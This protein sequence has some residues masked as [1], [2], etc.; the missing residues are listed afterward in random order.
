V[1]LGARPRGLP[2][3]DYVFLVSQVGPKGSPERSR[4]DE[5]HDGIVAPV[6]QQFD[7]SVHRA[8]RD[9]TPG[10][11]TTQ[12]IR[13]L[14]D[15]KI[16]VADLTGRNP[17][18]YYELG[19]AHAFQLPVAILVDKAA[20]LSFDTQN[21]KVIEIGDGGVIGVN[22]ARDAAAALKRV[23]EVVLSE[24]Y[25][26]ENL[27]TSVAAARSLDALA[28][29]NPMASELAAIR[30]QLDDV[31]TFVRRTRTVRRPDPEYAILRRFITEQA[32]MGVFS[33]EEL[34]DLIGPHTSSAFDRWINEM[35]RSIP[36][37]QHDLFGT[38]PSSSYD[39]DDEVPF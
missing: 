13:S 36:R 5:V 22:Q 29:A 19:V 24:E 37:S 25:A 2:V 32:K 15:A 10:Q 39:D 6:A 16:V 38:N 1:L 31:A 20:S 27:L 23:F 7:M 14:V 33:V 9:P 12:I 11:L 35:T 4:A 8:D 21:E 17:N 30:E 26:V 18:V 3:G 34:E 28:P